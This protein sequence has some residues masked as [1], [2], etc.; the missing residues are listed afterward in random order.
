MPLSLRP[1]GLSSPAYADHT[2]Y[3]VL[4]DGRIVGR[5]YEFRDSSMPADIR[6]FWSI[7]M[8]VH[9]EPGLVTDGR[10]PSLEE[11]KAQ[12]RKNW[13]KAKEIDPS[14]TPPHASLPQM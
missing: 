1:A 5:I 3:V 9:R 7:T 13:E 8:L 12:F 6:W 10:A 14:P 4:D 2:D 11:A